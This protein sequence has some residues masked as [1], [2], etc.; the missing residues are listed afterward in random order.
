MFRY[1]SNVYLPDW[2]GEGIAF[3][4]AADRDRMNKSLR[5][6]PGTRGPD[7]VRNIGSLSGFFQVKSI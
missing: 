3:W 1:R 4:V 2:L 7:A 5:G 6:Q